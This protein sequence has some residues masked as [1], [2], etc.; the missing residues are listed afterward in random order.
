MMQYWIMEND[1]GEPVA[2]PVSEI[3]FVAVQELEDD[4][5]RITGNVVWSIR[6]DHGDG[7]QCC[8]SPDFPTR[9]R[10]LGAF[11]EIIESNLQVVDVDKIARG[12]LK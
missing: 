8:W 7:V 9:E 2:I 5:A 11:R 3:V 6:V 10:A 1:L 4:E 12:W